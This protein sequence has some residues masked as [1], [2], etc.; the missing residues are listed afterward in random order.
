MIK[1]AVFTATRAEYGLMKTLIKKLIKS[2]YFD[3]QLIVS[4]THLDSN[5]GNTI[6]EIENDGIVPNYLL[7]IEIDP[8]RENDMNFQTAETIKGVTIALEKLKSKY[9]VVLGDRYESFAATIAANLMRIEIIHLHGGETTLGALDNKLRHSISQ[10][11]NL[12]FTSAEIHKKKVQTIT[13]NTKNIHNIGPMVIDGILNLSRISVKEFEKRTGFVFGENNFLVTFHSETLSKDFGLGC[14]KNLL[15]AL[16]QFNCNILFTSPNVDKGHMD[17]K[18][19]IYSYVNKKASQRFFV[20]SLG[21]ELYLNSL[22][23]FDSVIGNSSSGLIEAPIIGTKVLNIGDRQKGRFKFGEVIDVIND[24]FE[25][26]K[27]IKKII[28]S[29]SNIINKEKLLSKNVSKLISPS[30]LILEILQNNQ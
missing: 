6:K 11:S 8:F 15:Y 24:K 20:P 18:E 5:F 30:D 4:S 3:L 13:N 26:I 7:P 10:L 1:I 17:I 12:H 16:D 19:L 23:L 27:S 28:E 29:K 2:S 22:I 25:I 9:F 21:H 14:F